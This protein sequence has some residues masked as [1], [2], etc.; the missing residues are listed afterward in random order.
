MPHPLRKSMQTLI[1]IIGFLLLLE[2]IPGVKPFDN[3]SQSE[4]YNK[5]RKLIQGLAKNFEKY[6]DIHCRAF[7]IARNQGRSQ[8]IL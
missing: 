1:E 4:I 8:A 7:G 5:M 6:S 2:G 3:S